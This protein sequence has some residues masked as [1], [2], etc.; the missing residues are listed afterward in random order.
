MSRAQLAGRMQT[1][2]SDELVLGVKGHAGVMARLMP[3]ARFLSVD[4]CFHGQRHAVVSAENAYLDAHPG[5]FPTLC[6]RG[7]SL[8]SGCIKESLGRKWHTPSCAGAC[9]SPREPKPRY[10]VWGD[11]EGAGPTVCDTIQNR[12]SKRLVSRASSARARGYQPVANVPCSG[13]V[14]FFGV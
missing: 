9:W 8:T 1:C 13:R 12:E 10:A 2:R 4:A 3:R 11:G 14:L 6:P 7:Y 5:P